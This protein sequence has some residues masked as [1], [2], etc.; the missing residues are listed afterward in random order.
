MSLTSMPL[1]SNASQGDAFY[2]KTFQHNDLYWW[3]NNTYNDTKL[4]VFL[5][6]DSDK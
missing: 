2:N 5:A 6:G 1:A 4:T 3:G